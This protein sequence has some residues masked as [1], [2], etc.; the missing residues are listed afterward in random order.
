MMKQYLIIPS[1]FIFVSLYEGN[2]QDIVDASNSAAI[3]G[4]KDLTLIADHN[5]QSNFANLNKV[6]PNKTKLYVLGQNRKHYICDRS[7]VGYIVTENGHNRLYNAAYKPVYQT[8]QSGLV[9]YTCIVRSAPNV[10]DIRLTHWREV[11]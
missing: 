9:V 2:G 4:Y 7:E 6:K 1:L 10:M 5:N 11:I 3:W 8:E